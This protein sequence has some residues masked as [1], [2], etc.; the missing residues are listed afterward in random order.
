MK[1]A[2]QDEGRLIC[3][4]QH[5]VW[6][7]PKD[8]VCVPLAQVKFPTSLRACGATAPSPYDA[9]IYLNTGLDSNERFAITDSS[10]YWTSNVDAVL[11]F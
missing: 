1:S 3:S 11:F 9:V 10:D 7:Q 4:R 6:T 5:A 8:S 2:K